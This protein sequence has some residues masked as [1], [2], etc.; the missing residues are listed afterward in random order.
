[1]TRDRRADG[2]GESPVDATTRAGDPPAWWNTMVGQAVMDREAETCAK[3]YVALS[4]AHS[5][6][7]MAQKA[8]DSL[9]E[10]Q[11]PVPNEE[12]VRDIL[13]TDTLDAVEN[14]V[15]KYARRDAA[16]RK[17]EIATLKM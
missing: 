6:L 17:V 12:R 4:R 14:K 15:K 1:M 7:A 16:R 3:A 5:E 10:S 8:L 13:S 2:C 9:P 11:K